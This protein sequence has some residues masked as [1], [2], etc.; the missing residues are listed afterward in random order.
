MA[1]TFQGYVAGSLV[2][3]C[4][5]YSFMN[6]GT[7]YFDLVC[8]QTLLYYFPTKRGYLVALLKSMM[9]IGSSMTSILYQGFFPDRPSFFYF[10]MVYAI[11][12]A[13]LNCI[14]MRL[15]KYQTTGYEDRKLTP[16]EKEERLKLKA[17]YL[18]QE[19]PMIRFYYG[20]G[21]II[22]VIIFTT[23]ASAVINYVG[24]KT[25]EEI[26]PFSIVVVIL[27]AGFGLI[28]FPWQLFFGKKQGRQ[29]HEDRDTRQEEPAYDDTK[30][31]EQEITV[32]KEFDGYL[33]GAE[34]LAEM[35]SGSNEKPIETEVDF[36]APQYQ[37]SFWRNL[38]SINLWCLFWVFFIV[39]GTEL[40]IMN[41]ST[42]IFQAL[43]GHK[44]PDS[45]RYLLSVLNGVG[46]SAGRLSMS[47]FEV[48]IQS[49]PVEKRWPIT[50]T[51]FVPTVSVLITVTLLLALP[52]SVL[53]LPY[54]LGAVG[55]GFLGAILVLAPRTIYAKDNAK[56]YNFLFLATAC[57]SIVINRFLYGE[58]YAQQAGDT[59]CLRRAC[60]QPA[61]IVCV[62]VC[63][64][65]F[66]T[67]ILL[68]FRYRSFCRKVLR[69]RAIL[70]G[71]ITPEASEGNE[72]E[73]H[74]E[75]FEEVN[76]DN[77]EAI[78]VND[79]KSNK[80]ANRGTGI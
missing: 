2:R 55:N 31:P 36:I 48:W 14:F 4:V 50:V 74:G 49:R 13:V 63:T 38:L 60:V 30:K 5:F 77:G 33:E 53:P 42:Y 35:E 59:V 75:T 41:N 78:A 15:P 22:V 7:T 23:V 61:L 52:E 1:L 62:C 6:V 37:T 27:W 24:L 20:I 18:N 43:S 19:P 69:E 39:M 9:G 26:R 66:A 72:N 44:Q 25:H 80:S 64:T 54:V 68:H 16:E 70:R 46:S 12:F 67:N 8:T 76:L 56:H 73:N 28:M 10:L 3:L 32:A 45:L 79:T 57:S 47:F 17:P 65:A 40:M 51:L 71:E 29:D 58:W 11:I 34:E 21:L